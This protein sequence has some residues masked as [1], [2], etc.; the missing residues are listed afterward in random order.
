MS[1]VFKNNV[2]DSKNAIHKISNYRVLLEQFKNNRI[3]SDPVTNFFYSDDKGF[4]KT[5]PF[6][7]ILDQIEIPIFSLNGLT[8]NPQTFETTE[9]GTDFTITSS[10]S[11]H[12]FNLPF[13]SASTIGK[14][15]AD[16]WTAF[17]NKI[18]SASNGLT[19]TGTLIEL[20]GSLT[21]NTTIGDGNFSISFNNTQYNFDSALAKPV[22]FNG[23][24]TTSVW[25]GLTTG[26]YDSQRYNIQN[27]TGVNFTNTSGST[28]LF[29]DN[30]NLRVGVNTT[31][32]AHSFTNS[33][34]TISIGTGNIVTSGLGW[35]VNANGYIAGFKNSATS[36]SQGIF[37]N[38]NSVSTTDIILELRSSGAQPFIS[39]ND[40]FVAMGSGNFP[41]RGSFSDFVQFRGQ[42][43]FNIGSSSTNEVISFLTY[44]SA[45]SF[46]NNVYNN[47]GNKYRTTTSSASSTGI[48]F[49]N[50]F[51]ILVANE[52]GTAVTSGQTVN[53]LNALSVSKVGTSIGIAVNGTSAVAS[54]ILDINSTDK[55]VKFPNMTTVQKNAI[56][57]PALGLVVYDTTTNKL[58]VY[59]GTW[60]DLH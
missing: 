45:G 44:S 20:G 33:A 58:C 7:Y 22:R 1:G 52:N 12:S 50:I 30:A 11:I 57:S 53:W 3:D 39:Y 23:S 13:A 24:G 17:N 5:K 60:V 26:G 4:L 18:G 37:I 41:G 54:A 16:D 38:T 47:S 10:G 19:P 6:Q 25:H 29:V 21:K 28:S 59:D 36:G 46:A 31:S 51:R 27:S 56:S 35:S 48:Q 2:F 55:G 43:T 40:G 8:T 14:L 15:S 42:T 34:S 49:G 32:P 9:D